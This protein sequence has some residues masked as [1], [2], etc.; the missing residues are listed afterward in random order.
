MKGL[1]RT[2]LLVLIACS[3]DVFAQGYPNRPI[4]FVV[5]F[6]P[7]GST[8]VIARTVQPKLAEFL[9]QPVVIDNRVGA[10]GIVAAEYVARQPNDGYTM[11]LATAT[12]MTVHP[13]LHQ[14]LSYDPAKDFVAVGPTGD[15]FY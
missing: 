15:A 8:D 3:V 1:V 9:G 7:G 2:L 14:K 5:P 10:T 4:K 12:M 13:V 11:L 6:P